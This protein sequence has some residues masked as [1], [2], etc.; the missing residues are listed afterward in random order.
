[1]KILMPDDAKESPP[2]RRCERYCGA[3]GTFE[4]RKVQLTHNM[5]S[6]EWQGPYWV[7]AKCREHL[8]GFFRYA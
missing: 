5:R 6:G 4:M 8:R 1:M 7:C 2:L 3:E